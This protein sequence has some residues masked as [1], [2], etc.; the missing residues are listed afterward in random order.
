MRLLLD[1]HSFIWFFVGNPKLSTV[2]RSLI[3]DEDNE[4]LL[5]IASIWE[6]AIKHSQGKLSFGLP[7]DVFIEQQLSFEKLNLLNINLEHISAVATLP[8]HH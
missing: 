2:V 1:T 8:L 4:K 6:M 7:F 5:S 3:E